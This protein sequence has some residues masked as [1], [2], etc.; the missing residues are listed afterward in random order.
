[1]SKK[2][3]KNQ[4][5]DFTPTANP[6]ESKKILKREAAQFRVLDKSIG[7]GFGDKIFAGIRRYWND[8]IEKKK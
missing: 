6:D 1:M 4:D 8:W 2:S 7:A 5:I 3:S